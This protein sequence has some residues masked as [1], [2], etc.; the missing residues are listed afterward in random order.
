MAVV[1]VNIYRGQR[2]MVDPWEVQDMCQQRGARV[3]DLCQHDISVKLLQTPLF[4]SETLTAPS[5]CI[6]G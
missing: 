4:R 2:P 3:L 1:K 5:M 6:P